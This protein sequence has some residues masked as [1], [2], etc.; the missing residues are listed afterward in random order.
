MTAGSWRLPAPRALGAALGS[1][2]LLILAEPPF[3]LF[4][5]SFLALVPLAL[6]LW[7][8]PRG[9]EGRWQ[10]T[11]L[12]AAFGVAFWGFELVWVPVVVGMHFGWAFPGYLGLI[13][14][15]GGLSA[16]LGRW[17]HDL[18]FPGA[19]PGKL[20]G[21]RE[22]TALPLAWVGIEW[23]RAHAPFGLAWPWLGLG[24]ALTERPELLGIAEWVG[25]SGVSFWVAGVNGA[26][27]LAILRG[28]APRAGR[29][30]TLVGLA[31]AV[32]SLAGITRASS[33]ELDGGPTV[34][35]V[36]TSILPGPRGIPSESAREAL[37][38][39]ERALEPIQA[40]EVDL[41][42]LPE[43]TV[44]FPVQSPDA[45]E[46]LSGLR[47][48]AD[49][50]EVPLVFGGIGR[51]DGT[52]VR[53]GDGVLTNSAF[54]L[55]S[56]DAGLQRYDKTR[57][58][59]VMEGGSYGRDSSLE[60]FE[61]EDWALGPL[62][63]YESIFGGLARERIRHGAQLLLNL[64]SDIWFGHAESFLGSFFLHQHP[65]HLV[66]RVVENRV[67]VA[68][69]ANGGLSFVLDPLGRS[70]SKPVPAG[71]GTVISPVVV[72][73]GRTLYSRVG[74]WVGPIS[75]A[76]VLLLLLGRFPRVRGR[77]GTGL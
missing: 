41:V 57:L 4:P 74:D 47:A 23:I 68:R 36:G 63:C 51:V 13:L 25:E 22:A 17:V 19:S 33:L 40:G 16:L 14:V 12:G 43:G 27:A 64:S 71:G 73:R 8:L 26:V 50:L 9:P 31:V 55:L 77:A 52:D 7:T 11:V 21:L 54:L 1:A 60:V 29:I 34:A 62:I 44:P 67:P 66:M 10:A 38:Q 37:S 72:Y 18:G 56:A 58:V 76:A 20:S 45:R 24:I 53:P 6:S 28:R 48:M 2:V 30:W 39:I 65:A 42:I 59:P 46:F 32:P 75:L 15:L 35:A 61:L 49:R 5:L 70:V 69:A 3:G